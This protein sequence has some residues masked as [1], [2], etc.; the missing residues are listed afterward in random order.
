MASDQTITF[1]AF[2]DGM[3]ES[4]PA[5]ESNESEFSYYDVTVSDNTIRQY[6]NSVEGSV[7]VN[8]ANE[9]PEYEHGTVTLCFYDHKGI[10]LEIIPRSVEVVPGTNKVE[11]NDINLTGTRVKNADSITCK[12]ISWLSGEKI[13]PISDVLEF[14]LD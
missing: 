14:K 6:K 4:I 7:V 3:N 10:L 11:F 1:I 9:L 5:I 8:I 13:T 2:A 12:V